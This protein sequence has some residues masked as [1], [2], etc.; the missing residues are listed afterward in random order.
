MQ[1]ALSRHIDSAI[2][3]RLCTFTLCLHRMSH[4]IDDQIC[5]HKEKQISSASLTLHAKDVNKAPH[6]ANISIFNCSDTTTT[7]ANVNS[8]S[9]TSLTLPIASH[10][11][12]SVFQNHCS[13]YIE[14]QAT[15]K[16]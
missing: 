4:N 1:R 8:M 3:V 6:H 7:V 10:D 13:N 14:S 5:V 11:T 2:T 16:G 15:S 9:V 12:S